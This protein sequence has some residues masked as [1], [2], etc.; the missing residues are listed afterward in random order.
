VRCVQ[1][2]L[3]NFR[4]DDRALAESLDKNEVVGKRDFGGRFHISRRDQQKLRQVQNG[5]WM[6][7]WPPDMATPGVKLVA[8]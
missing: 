8:S 4:R 2:A 3:D 7:V 6:T 1:Y 5:R